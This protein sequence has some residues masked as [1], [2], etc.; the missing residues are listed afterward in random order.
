MAPPDLYLFPKLKSHL[1][2]TKYG[3]NEGLKEV[4]NEYLADQ[5]KAFYF[6]GI[7]KLEQKWSK[8]IALMGYYI[9]QKWSNFHSLVAQSTKG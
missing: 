5:K 6:A 4:V 8:C 3:S 9:E 7:R 2:G 1:R